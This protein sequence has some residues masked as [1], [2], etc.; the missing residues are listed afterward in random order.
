MVVLQRIVELVVLLAALLAQRLPSPRY[1]LQQ[2]LELHLLLLVLLLAVTAGAVLNSAMHFVIPT[3]H[4]VVV[5]R[6][7]DTAV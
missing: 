1:R 3:V 5:A 2:V 6:K 7:S 4:T